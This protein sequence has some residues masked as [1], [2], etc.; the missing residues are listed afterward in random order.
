MQ[1]I[2]LDDDH[3]AESQRFLQSRNLLP[4]VRTPETNGAAP[5]RSMYPTGVNLHHGA[6]RY[7]TD[8]AIQPPDLFGQAFPPGMAGTGGRDRDRA[9]SARSTVS[10][11]TAWAASTS[12]NEVSVRLQL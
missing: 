4:F 11:S 8:A 2:E 1:T 7:G 10:P 12:S 3:A 9:T 5:T 6:A